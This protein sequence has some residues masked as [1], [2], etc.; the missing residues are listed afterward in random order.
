MKRRKFV[1]NTVAGL[2]LALLAPSAFMACGGEESPQN[3]PTPERK[4]S[5]VIIGAGIAGLAA[6]KKLKDN[7]FT[8]TVLESQAKAGG[9]L[10]TDRSLGV[11]FDEGAS[12]IHG[13]NGNPIT[14]L[15]SQA[16]ASSFLTNDEL[17]SVYDINGSPYSDGVFSS[18]EAA[19]NNA[20]NSVRSGGRLNESFET[21]F[22]RLFP[23]RGN[24]RLWK[25]FLSAY[26]EF[27][28]AGDIS[29]LSSVQFDDDE[30]FGGADVIITNGFD[31]ITDFLAQ[32]LDIRLNTRVSAINYASDKVRVTA[33]V[34]TIEA[35]FAVVTVPLGIL[36]RNVI[37]FTPA[38]PTDK[39]EAIEKTGMGNVNKFLL[40]WDNTFWDNNLQYIGITPGTKGMFNYF[41]NVNKFAASANALMAFAFGGYADVSEQLSD[42]QVIDGV[43]THLKSIHGNNIPSP[44]S[45]LRTKW[46]QE[47]NT[48][49]AYSFASAGISTESFDV[50][51]KAVADKVFFAGEHT[52][53][54]YRGTVHGAYLTGIREADKVLA[55]R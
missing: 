36:K 35:D 11:P 42:A 32:G 18:A 5:A 8:V 47:P 21:V 20:L 46:G 12:W 22:N 38:L 39:T 16:G 15:A 33:G 34:T 4:N 44:K 30:M 17:V 2:P 13:P 24:E 23:G 48:F 26:L 51:A 29:K 40:V 41:L 25:Y 52:S 1:N 49:G 45:M 6:A 54:T 27:S 43:M 14:A 28:T 10:K 31:K 9:R 53:R 50:L 37:S 7:G 3:T 55:I 19:Y